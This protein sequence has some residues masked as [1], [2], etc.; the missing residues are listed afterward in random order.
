MDKASPARDSQRKVY[1]GLGPR[2]D[3]SIT[4]DIA[5]LVDI[6]MSVGVGDYLIFAYLRDVFPYLISRPADLIAGSPG[7]SALPYLSFAS[8]ISG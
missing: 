7:L 4:G 1:H 5:N 6:S 8:I 3:L 2:R